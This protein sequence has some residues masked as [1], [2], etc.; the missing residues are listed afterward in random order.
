MKLFKD[1]NFINTNLKFFADKKDIL[2]KNI[3]GNIENI[4]ISDG[5]LKLNFDKGIKLNSNFN[6]KIKLNKKF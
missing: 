2:I 1:L 3:F 6:F 5:D 4:K